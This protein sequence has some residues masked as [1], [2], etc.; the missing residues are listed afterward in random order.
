MAH[1]LG[2]DYTRLKQRLDGIPSR[3][4][5]TGEGWLLWKTSLYPGTDRGLSA[6]EPSQVLAEVVRLYSSILGTA[7]ETRSA[8]G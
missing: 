8:P 4:S 5:S 1:P 7:P 6:G 3:N 2:L